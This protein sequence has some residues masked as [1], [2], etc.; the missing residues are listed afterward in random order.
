VNS[1]E[2]DM[3]RKCRGCGEVFSSDEEARTHKCKNIISTD[4]PGVW[5][6]K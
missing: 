3:K 2:Y 1:K 4:K 6:P 5:N